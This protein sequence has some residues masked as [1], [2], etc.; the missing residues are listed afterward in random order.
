[1]PDSTHPAPDVP[2]RGVHVIP[3]SA[4]E[5]VVPPST[6]MATPRPVDQEPEEAAAWADR[7]PAGYHAAV[8]RDATA[9]VDRAAA[10]HRTRTDVWLHR[11]HAALWGVLVV[12]LIVGISWWAVSR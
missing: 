4:P 5:G 8:R 3:G 12:W 9:I 1:M 6:S 11:A 7:D 2:A 10:R